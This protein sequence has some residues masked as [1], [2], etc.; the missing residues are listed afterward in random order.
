MNKLDRN[1]T[2]LC[3]FYELTMA[4]GYL[5]SGMKD[6]IVY[7]DVFYRSNPDHGG[8]A[9]AAGLEQVV[10]YI[11]DLH[12]DE[13][14][15]EYLRSKGY[16]SEEF[17][18]YLRNF[19]FEGDIWAIPEGTVVFPGEPLMIVRAPVIQAQFIETMVL[20]CIKNF[21]QRR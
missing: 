2:M 13:D 19:K 17:L 6:K 3:D 5:K 18:E 9:I 21:K 16:F 4:N 14:D 12:F 20:L 7:F 1:L 8:Q 15:I 11:N 10:E